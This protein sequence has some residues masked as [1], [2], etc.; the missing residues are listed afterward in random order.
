MFMVPLMVK[1]PAALL[2]AEF[3]PST[4]SMEAF[5]ELDP[6]VGIQLRME[7]SFTVTLNLL[8]GERLSLL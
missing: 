5:P 2:A 1:V 6:L 4:P 7:F 3:P 8:P